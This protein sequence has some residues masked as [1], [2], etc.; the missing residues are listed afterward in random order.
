[1]NDEGR[2]N[3]E[4]RGSQVIRDRGDGIKPNSN[5]EGFGGSDATATIAID[6]GTCVTSQ[7]KRPS[8]LSKTHHIA[9]QD[10]TPALRPTLFL[11]FPRPS[12]LLVKPASR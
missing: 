8:Q 7:D 5:F 6:P 10:S 9:R 3:S 4:G 12:R 11:Y 2:G 1:M